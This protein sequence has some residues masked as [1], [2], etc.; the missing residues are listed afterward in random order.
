MNDREFIAEWKGYTN[1]SGFYDP[2]EMA[3]LFTQALDRLE[4]RLGNYDKAFEGC[5]ALVELGEPVPVEKYEAAILAMMDLKEECDTLMNANEK[6]DLTPEEALVEA[7]R[8]WGWR[9]F[10]RL[11][12]CE[13]LEGPPTRTCTIGDI[14]D[15]AQEITFRAAFIAADAAKK[16]GGK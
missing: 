13:N 4:A 16:E 14:S 6:R 9:A 10:V 5:R 8:R 15:K 3:G 7:K 1:S 2:Q 12:L 11:H